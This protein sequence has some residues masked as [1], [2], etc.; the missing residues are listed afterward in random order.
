MMATKDARQQWIGCQYQL[1]MVPTH[2]FEHLQAIG[3]RK[4]WKIDQVMSG[5]LNCIEKGNTKDRMYEDKRK[6]T[7]A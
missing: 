1:Y 2:A 3:W 4:H 5:A 6:V 7:V